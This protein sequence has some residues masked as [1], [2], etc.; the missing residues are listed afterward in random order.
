M[1]PLQ[2]TAFAIA[3]DAARSDVEK[4]LVEI[5]Q[6]EDGTRWYDLDDSMLGLDRDSLNRSIDYLEQ[7]GRIA[8][9]PDNASW[10]RV[11]F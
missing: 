3:D 8:H 5:R 11:N 6:D 1:T 2:Q 4:F 9:H 7:R 10:V